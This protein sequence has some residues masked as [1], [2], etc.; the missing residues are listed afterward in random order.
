MPTTND[1]EV[2]ISKEDEA[3]IPMEG[4]FEDPRGAVVEVAYIGETRMFDSEQLQRAWY[5]VGGGKR[6]NA[7]RLNEL[8]EKEAH[9]LH[10]HV[11][12]DLRGVYK[13]DARYGPELE[14]RV[15]PASY[16]LCN[17]LAR[18]GSNDPSKWEM[19]KAKAINRSGF[20]SRHGG[21]LC[22]LDRKRIDWNK[23]PRHIRFKYGKLPVE[24]LDDEELAKG[25]IRKENGT[26]T[27]NNFVSA[28]IH[29]RMMQE[30]FD[31]ADIRLRENLVL[32]VDTAAEIASGTVY[33]EGV[34]LQAA[35]WMYET[36]RGKTPQKVEIGVDKKFE[37]V[38]DAIIVGGSRNERK[39]ERGEEI[40]E[41]ELVDDDLDLPDLPAMEEIEAAAAETEL[42]TSLDYRSPHD[43]PVRAD[44]IPEKPIHHGAAGRE[45][46]DHHPSEEGYAGQMKLEDQAIRKAEEKR[47]KFLR[48]R[49][50]LKP[51]PAMTAKERGQAKKD[52]A[53]NKRKHLAKRKA[54]QNMGEHDLPVPLKLTVEDL[55]DKEGQEMELE[56]GASLESGD[57]VTIAVAITPNMKEERND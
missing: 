10:H 6:N 48:K 20:C 28:E 8:G 17:G 1:D 33:D 41:A 57:S 55:H 49:P 23:A 5:L 45:T 37:Q 4:T 13:V 21:A 19:C 52:H 25:Q 53:E 54:F 27:Q 3:L 35:K 29:K 34:R 38:M 56:E 30:L 24:D 46:Y 47:K 51:E 26:F 39:Q 44:F 43:R 36:V 12:L 22:P 7:L 15:G 50:D 16:A 18:H 32:A 2:K 42:E 31:R 14:E 40:V 11:P 9:F